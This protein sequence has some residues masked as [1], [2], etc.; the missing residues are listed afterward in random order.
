M[1]DI[2]KFEN[3][4]KFYKKTAAEKQPL[5]IRSEILYRTTADNTFTKDN[6]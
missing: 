1:N 4:K 3:V 2:I 6:W 5:Y